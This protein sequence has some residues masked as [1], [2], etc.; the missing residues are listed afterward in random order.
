MV[1]SFIDLFALFVLL[2]LCSCAENVSRVPHGIIAKLQRHSIPA[3][4]ADFP[5]GELRLRYQWKLH[6]GTVIHTPMSTELGIPSIKGSVNGMEVPLILDTGNAFPILFDAASAADIQIPSIQGA[7]AKGA[8]IGG[9][10]DVM[11]ARY[12]S[13]HLGGHPVLGAGIAGVFLHSY[14]TTFAGM[15]VEDKPLNL[16]GLPLLGQF[17]FLSIDA[18]RQKVSLAYKRPFTPPHGAVYFPFSITDGRIWV[19]VKIEDKEVRAFFDSGCGSSLRIPPDIL[20]TIPKS[21]FVSENLQKR[22]A[23]GVGGI[24]IERVGK[25][26]RAQV[27]NVRFEPLEFDT[28]PGSNEA[29][30]GWGPFSKHR[31]TIDFVEHKIWVEPTQQDV[32]DKNRN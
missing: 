20:K 17:S 19:V 10:V 5:K 14:R 4:P 13:I 9:T 15:T 6:P 27:G 1:R 12:E 18:P 25:F 29:L 11:M 2:L 23:M 31:I 24:E 7:K 32:V 3:D 21:A 8:G 16:L 28:S 22:R 26:K 30:I